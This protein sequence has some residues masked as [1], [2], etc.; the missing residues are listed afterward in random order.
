MDEEPSEIDLHEDEH[1]NS[2]TGIR[3]DPEMDHET[4]PRYDLMDTESHT[5]DSSESLWEL[6]GIQSKELQSNVQ[7]ELGNPLRSRRGQD[8]YQSDGNET[9]QQAA[10][11]RYQQ[12]A[13]RF[14]HQQDVERE[15]ARIAED[16]RRQQQLEQLR[17]RR[18]HAERLKRQ[19][20]RERQRE[21]QRKADDDRRRR[22]EE[23]NRELA[24]LE[25]MRK[26][27][28]EKKR[29]EDLSEETIQKTTRKCPG[30]SWSIEK[31][32]GC[33]HMTC[34]SFCL[35]CDL[36]GVLARSHCH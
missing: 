12:E 17:R 21:R 26:Q 25:K 14:R 13:D 18:E 19:L 32:S 29:Q 27:A 28:I 20:K 34:K 6:V 15:R 16:A 1:D 24:R 4:D 35:S 2:S 9:N 8:T 36:R 11:S 30:C 10:R 7:A 5:P 33:D 31:S 3:E 23:A 22:Q